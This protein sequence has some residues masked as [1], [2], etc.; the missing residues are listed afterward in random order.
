MAS[1]I[2]P[3]IM[4]AA[5]I[6]SRAVRPQTE[7]DQVVLRLAGSNVGRLS[8]LPAVI[9]YTVFRTRP[10]LRVRS[11]AIYLRSVPEIVPAP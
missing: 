7:G 8:D 2:I 1:G 11:A 3:K 6:G 4:A 10:L 5:V 9:K